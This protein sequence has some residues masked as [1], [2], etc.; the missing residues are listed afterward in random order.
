MATAWLN[1]FFTSLLPETAKFTDPKFAISGPHHIRLPFLR[2]IASIDS[3][4][5]LFVVLHAHVN[6]IAANRYF[7]M[8]TMIFAHIIKHDPLPEGKFILSLYR[9]TNPS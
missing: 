1:S 7:F 5:G 2:L 3:A 6:A 9:K 8:T 4:D